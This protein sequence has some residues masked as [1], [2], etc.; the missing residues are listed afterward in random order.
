MIIKAIMGNTEMKYENLLRPYV[1]VLWVFFIVFLFGTSLQLNQCCSVA[2]KISL[3][4]C[5]FR[6][7]VN[8]CK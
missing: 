5:N 1:Q 8:C 7:N 4:L 2:Y 6:T 3:V